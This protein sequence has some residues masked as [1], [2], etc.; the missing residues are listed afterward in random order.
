MS[1][2]PD[3]PSPAPSDP[4][5]ARL[6]NL[7]DTEA[8]TAV[9]PAEAPRRRVTP[10]IL[11]GIAAIL[12]SCGALVVSIVQVSIL[13]AQQSAS[14]WPRLQVGTNHIDDDYRVVLTNAGVGPAV[15]RE[16][17]FAVHGRSYPSAWALLKGEVGAD[18]LYSTPKYFA[19]AD[20][21]DVVRAGD[22][23]ELLVTPNNPA[24]SNRLD[25]ITSDT[26]FHARFLYSDVYGACWRLD[27]ERT[28]AAGRCA[29]A[30]G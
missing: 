19:D 29:E 27:N 1:A 21:G 18:T 30:E 15:V 14:V 17:E 6:G 28:R 16:A 26:S 12:L 3:A 2:E 10:E 25:A 8:R 9:P 5:E 20:P 24:V 23:V 13:R 4:T 11:V 7:P 22:T